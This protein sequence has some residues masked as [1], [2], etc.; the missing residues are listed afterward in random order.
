MSTGQAA[1]REW[2]TCNICKKLH[3]EEDLSC[4]P[5]DPS[6]N[7]TKAPYKRREYESVPKIGG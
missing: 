4:H 3:T 1:T 2:Y 7:Y 5:F 6:N